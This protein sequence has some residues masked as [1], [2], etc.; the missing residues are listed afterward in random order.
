MPAQ[1]V[2]PVAPEDDVTPGADNPNPDVRPVPGGKPLDPPPSVTRAADAKKADD[3]EDEVIIDATDWFLAGD[4]EPMAWDQFDLNVSA[5]PTK[6]KW[7]RFRIESIDRD[8]MKQIRDDASRDGIED[9]VLA[10]ELTA[11]QG[12]THPDLSDPAQRGGLADPKDVLRKMLGHK[13]LLI[14][15]IARR[16]SAISGGSFADVR[17]VPKSEQERP[18]DVTEVSAAGN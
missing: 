8:M 17:E 6:T 11:I 18:Q 7:V 12:M 16:I 10:N 4:A 3:L 9:D 5:D 2:P 15:T 1:T 13:P 14:D